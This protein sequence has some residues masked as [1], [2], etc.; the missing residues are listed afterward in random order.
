MQAPPRCARPSPMP[1]YAD[2]SDAT[3]PRRPAGRQ[4]CRRRR[5]P[6][7]KR[8]S[9]PDAAASAAPCDRR[10]FDTL[11][12]PTSLSGASFQSSASAGQ[13]P[14]RLRA[15]GPALSLAPPPLPRFALSVFRVTSPAL[16]CCACSLT[17]SP[18]CS[19]FSPSVL[20]A[21]AVPTLCAEHSTTCRLYF[22]H[23]NVCCPSCCSC[24]RGPTRALRGRPRPMCFA[25]PA[26]SAALPK[27]AQMN[28]CTWLAQGR[29]PLA[30]STSSHCSKTPLQ[31]ATM[32]ESLCLPWR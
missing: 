5:R 6:R 27:T 14:Q 1:H 31:P 18:A 24:P 10:S 16:L 13:R 20:T 19:Y 28:R 25:G 29:G 11:F 12:N 4:L 7:Q 2:L 15:A 30:P 9:L 3:A 22:T 32:K 21:A 8:A 17:L 26:F 23:G